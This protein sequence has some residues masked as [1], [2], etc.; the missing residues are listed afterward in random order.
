MHGE[1]S[2]FSTVT[3][4]IH[5]SAEFENVPLTVRALSSLL[6]PHFNCSA[7]QC[8][9]A[10]IGKGFALAPVRASADPVFA[11]NIA[12]QVNDRISAA[13]YGLNCSAKL[14]A[15]EVC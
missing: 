2:P 14:G 3:S 13:V 9:P 1:P 12:V 6:V 7:L 4:G 11:W 5:L 8:P 10:P 15:V